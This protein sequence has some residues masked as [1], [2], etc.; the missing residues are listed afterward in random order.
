MRCPSFERLIDYLDGKSTAAVASDVRQHLEGGCPNCTSI[1]Q[2]Y[3]KILTVSSSDDSVEP[4][5]WVLKRAFRIFDAE[6]SKPKLI[7]RLGRAVAEL[8]FD[9]MALPVIEGVRATETSSRQLLY[10]VGA[11]SIDLH[12]SHSDSQHADLTGQVL[13]EGEVSFESV[14]MRA[15]TLTRGSTQVL[16]TATNAMGE[17]AVNQLDAAEYGLLVEV[18]EGT[19]VVDKLPLTSYR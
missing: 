9:S 1:R 8:V 15:L 14:A 16:E 19:L 12:I 10:E 2:W 4:P 13:R 17:F 11:Y 6:K 7:E 18:A 3:E 5:P